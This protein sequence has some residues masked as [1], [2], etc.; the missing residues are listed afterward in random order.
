MRNYKWLFLCLLSLVL[1]S[2]LAIY[3]LRATPT[4][5]PVLRLTYG[6]KGVPVDAVSQIH[7]PN[8]GHLHAA[9]VTDQFGDFYILSVKRDATL[10]VLRVPASATTIEDAYRQAQQNVV[11]VL[12]V[13][14]AGEVK[15][16][17]PLRRLDGRLVR[18]DCEFLAVS[19]SG[20]RLWT[21]RQAG[22]SPKDWKHRREVEKRT[23]LL[24]VYDNQGKPLAEWEVPTI[25]LAIE[26]FAM[27]ATETEAYVVP[28]FLKQEKQ[29]LIYRLG[30]QQ[31]QKHPWPSSWHPTIGAS[32]ITTSGQFWHLQP[33]NKGSVSAY[34]TEFGEPSRLFT[35]FQWHREMS[36]PFLF[37]QDAQAGLF[38]FENLK[39]EKGKIRFA[40]GAKAV[41]RIAPD[42][43]LHKL[44][45]TPDV[46][47]AKSGEQVRAGQL[48]KASAHFV[49]MEA[50]YLK[51]GKATEYQ[52]VKVPI[53]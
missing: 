46:L 51:D 9:V 22:E 19:A 25:A 36:Y 27:A 43:A 39:D 26:T 28:E 16:A 50:T 12:I 53:S 44:F 2:G 21:L 49:W 11:H 47:Q 48:L 15:R 6:A 10:K 42:G 34:V 35:T 1:C 33:Q 20:E 40:D 45:E 3:L 5:I 7:I 18:G 38:V 14:E 37:W 8:K 32:L 30:Q 13:S 23:V 24:N 52:I 31:P 29:F 4:A 17:V 41:Y